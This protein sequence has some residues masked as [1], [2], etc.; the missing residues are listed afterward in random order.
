MTATFHVDKIREV[1]WNDW[2]YEN[3]VFPDETKDDLLLLVKNH[4]AM[5]KS[6]SDVI[7]GKGN[8]LTY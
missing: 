2:A 6:S 1:R 3:L 5:K 8:C 7:P 4:G